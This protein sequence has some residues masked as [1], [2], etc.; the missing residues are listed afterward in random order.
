[1]YLLIWNG[2]VHSYGDAGKKDGIVHA[3]GDD[4]GSRAV[5]NVMPFGMCQSMANPAV[6][7]ATAAA[8]GVLTPMPCIPGDPGA[9]VTGV[10]DSSRRKYAGVE[11]EFEGH[12]RLWRA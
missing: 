9:V 1:M 6:A 3:G 4:H 2:T 10:T 5:K 8:F 12:L 7:A 11:P